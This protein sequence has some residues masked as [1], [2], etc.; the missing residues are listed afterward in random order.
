MML[1]YRPRRRLQFTYKKIVKMN[2]VLWIFFNGNIHVHLKN[3]NEIFDQKIFDYS[4]I[5]THQ[6]EH[7]AGQPVLRNNTL[8][9]YKD[10]FR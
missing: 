9:K 1:I 6:S 4:A 5:T 3:T 10:L 8:Q 7:T 2:I